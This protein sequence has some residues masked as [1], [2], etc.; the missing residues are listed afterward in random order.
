[1]R[2]VSKVSEREREGTK[3]VIVTREDTQNEESTVYSKR[4]VERYLRR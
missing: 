4:E 3:E 1:M 2:R